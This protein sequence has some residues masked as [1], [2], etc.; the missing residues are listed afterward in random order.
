VFGALTSR[1]RG[2]ARVMDIHL[3]ECEV[4]ETP[5]ANIVRPSGEV[6]L[7]TVSVLRHALAT[8]VALGRHV[9][10]DLSNVTFIDSTGFRE[11]LIHRRMCR[12]DDRLMVL[13]NPRPSVQHV[14][15]MLNFYQMIPVFPSLEVAQNNLKTPS[16]PVER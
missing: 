7:S 3:L 2:G 15:D 11:L 8:A 14:I 9:V 12:E 5:V 6:D 16:R 4:N 13:V 10:V 1:G